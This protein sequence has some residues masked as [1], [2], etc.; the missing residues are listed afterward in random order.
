MS[1]LMDAKFVALRGQG[2]T[3]TMSDMTLQWL[4]A[5]GALSNAIPDAWIEMLNAQGAGSLHISDG[6]FRLLGMLGYT[7]NANDRQLQ[8]WLAGGEFPIPPPVTN[9]YVNPELAGGM[10]PTAHTIGF[11]T[12]NGVMLDNGDGTFDYE[13]NPSKASGRHYLAYDLAANNPALEVGGRYRLEVPAELVSIG[14]GTTYAAA[15]TVSTVSN[16]T[17]SGAFSIAAIGELR[18]LALEFTVDALPYT[19]VFRFGCGTTAVSDAHLVY[20]YS[21][22][23]RLYKLDDAAF[24]N[25]FN[26]GF[27]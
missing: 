19:A 23:R 13:S 16:L 15:L 27:A 8:F 18:T 1:T 20:P 21:P 4:K 5:N 6:W 9:L 12:T 11:G 2:F 24:S 22:N 7:G 26:E 14:S 25:G 10:P 3:G 17:I